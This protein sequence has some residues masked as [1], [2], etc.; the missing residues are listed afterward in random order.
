MDELS[1]SSESSLLLSTARFL[2]DVGGTVT[3]FKFF[4]FAVVVAAVGLLEAKESVPCLREVVFLTGAIGI[5]RRKDMKHYQFMRTDWK[6][7]V[8]FKLELGAVSPRRK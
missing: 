5:G 7:V 2:E 4:C 6:E 1:I 8:E 3:L